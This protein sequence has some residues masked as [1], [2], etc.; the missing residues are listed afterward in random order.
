[1][2]VSSNPLAAALLFAANATLSVPW[3]ALAIAAVV[4][5]YLAWKIVA[6]CDEKRKLEAEITILEGGEEKL[7]DAAPDTQMGG[8]DD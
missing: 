8:A 4:F 7:G 5:V 3:W 1:M 6:L 2:D